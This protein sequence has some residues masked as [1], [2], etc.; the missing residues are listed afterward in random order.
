M[1][2]LGLGI[3]IPASPEAGTTAVVVLSGGQDSVTCLGLALRC[4]EKVYAVG[5]EYG[6]KHSVE[7]EQA[8]KICDAHSVPFELFGIPALAELNDSALIGEGGDVNQPHHRKPELPASFVPNRN[9][10]FLTIAH[11]YAQKVEADALVT[12]VCQTDYSGYPDCRLQ[13]IQQLEMALNI[14]Y[15]CNIKIMTPL[16]HLNKAQTFA[17]AEECNFLD[18]VI[19]ES[20]TCYNG[21]RTTLREWGAGCGECPACKLREA[22]YVDYVNGMF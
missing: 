7:L 5:F 20:H 12:G 10:L 3:N 9:A 19:N 17:L 2:K 22:G 18:V 11:A 16:M 21:D 4:F 13:F 8:K 14:G 6:Q 15:N 1:S